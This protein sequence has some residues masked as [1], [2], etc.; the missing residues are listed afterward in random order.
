MC[1]PCPTGTLYYFRGLL[2]I[3]Q[4]ALR[5]KQAKFR[6]PVSLDLRD[7]QVL[8]GMLW[9]PLLKQTFHSESHTLLHFCSTSSLYLTLRLSN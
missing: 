8:H 2:G 9:S 1:Q 6:V 7:L 5:Q 3:T 4:F